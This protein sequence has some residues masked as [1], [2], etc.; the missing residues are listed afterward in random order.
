MSRAVRAFWNA[1]SHA[2][3]AD[4]AA[5]A[6]WSTDWVTRGLLAI[7]RLSCQLGS[8]PTSCGEPA[9]AAAMPQISV[10]A[11]PPAIQIARG[12]DRARPLRSPRPPPGAPG[13]SRCVP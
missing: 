11:P 13:W 10:G 12:D 9:A 2:L 7:R 8:L 5:L 4:A 6:F 3:V 1:L